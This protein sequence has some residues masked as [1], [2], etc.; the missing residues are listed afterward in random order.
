MIS[1]RYIIPVDPRDAPV[2]RAGAVVVGSGVAGLYTALKLADFTEVAVLCK[3][4]VFDSN[5]YAAQGGIAAAVGAGD[6]PDLHEE[7]TLAAGDGLNIRPA[8]RVVVK[9]SP[10]AVKDLLRLGALFDRA[11]EELALAREAAHSRDRV[12]HAGGDATGRELVRALWEQV[13]GKPNIRIYE[14]AAVADVLTVKGRCVGVVAHTGDRGW[15]V[16]SAPATVL[17]TG[18][19]GQLYRLTTNPQGATGD[20]VA[21]A[22]RAGAAVRDLEFIQFHPTAYSGSGAPSFLLSEALRGEGAILRNVRGDRFMPGYHPMAELAPRDVVARAI[23]MEMERTESTHV[24]L[25]ITHKSPDWLERR[26]PTIYR[27]CRSQGLHL[28]SDWIPVAPAAHYMMGGI[29]TD[30]WGCTTVSGLFAVGE[31]ASTGV[32]GANRLASNSLVEGIVFGKRTADRVRRYLEE[33]P[34]L[35]WPPGGDGEE[36][37]VWSPERRCLAAG[38]EEDPSSLRLELQAMMSR[39]VGVVRSADSLTRALSALGRWSPSL[40]SAGRN[41]DEIEW[42]NLMTVARL[43]AEAAWFRTESRGAHFRRDYPARDDARWRVHIVFSR[44][45]GGWK[46]RCP[47]WN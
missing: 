18:G 26:F 6:S 32:H 8:V 12:L 11:G 33:A 29:V 3:G 7:D 5:S 43:V 24:Y 31:A 42:I 2:V 35:S 39:E 34:D 15:T 21:M 10:E 47:E 17:A 37:A 44:E 20:G 4:G 36:A 22:F 13:R 14:K 45:G 30:L 16:F 23:V 9:E 41:R 40:L 46:V 1:S 25:D 28:G 19:A 27:F 38:L